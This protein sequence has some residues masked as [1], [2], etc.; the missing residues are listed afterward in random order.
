M[1]GRKETGVELRRQR[2]V[3]RL[4]EAGRRTLGLRLCFHDIQRRSGLP[5][6]LCVQADPVCLKIRRGSREAD[7]LCVEFDYIRTHQELPAL[8]HGRIQSCP[9]GLIALTVPVF[10]NGEFVG[11]LFAGPCWAGRGQPLYEGV[12]RSGGR[13]WLEDRLLLLRGVA[14]SMGELLEREAF[15]RPPDRRQEVEDYLRTHLDGEV[16]L[17]ELGEALGLS[18]SRTSHVIGQLFGK[19]F[20]QLLQEARVRQGALLLAT[21]DLPVAEVARLCG[22]ADANYFSRLFRKH[23][24]CT[25]LE[26]RTRNALLG[27]TERIK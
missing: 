2:K 21:S 4:M 25:P 1:A 15:Y 17:P 27:R 18:P 6:P 7:A 13:E 24:R 16:R 12:P 14:L 19:S 23:N 20:S 8:P 5:R 11:V 10:A 22:L 9:H 3:L 26:Y